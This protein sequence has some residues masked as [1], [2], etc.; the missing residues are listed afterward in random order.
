MMDEL[1]ATSTLFGSNAPFIEQQYEIY[2][3]DPNAVGADWRA[4]F[5]QLRDGASDVAHAPVIDSFIQLAKSRRLAAPMV[6]AQA[7]H[8]Q[9]LV[10]RL[11]SK[12]RT[13]GVFQADLDPLK[14]QEKPYLADLDLASYGFSEADREAEF[15]IGSYRGAPGGGDR[16]RLRDLIAALQETYCRTFATEYMYMSDTPQKRFIQER[17]EPLRSRP[18]YSPE[19]R[20]HILERLTAAETLERYLGTKYVGQKRFSGEGGDSMIPMLDHLIQTSGAAGVQ[21]MVIGM[22][23]RGRLNVLVN[24]LGK[25]PANLFAEFEGKSASDLSAG[26]VK[27]HQGFSSDVATPGGPMHVTLAFNPSHLEIVNPVV[28]GSVRARQ[29]RRK[30]GTFDQVMPVLIHG[31]AAIAGQGVV[32]ET[33]NLSQTRGFRTGGTIHIVVNNQ[34]GFTT[35]DPRDTRG[36]LYCTDV[37][38]MVEAPIFHVNGD[39]PEA[40]LLAIEIAIEFRQ[41]FDRDV[42]IDLVCFRRQGHNEADE[43]M[44][45]QP[46]MYKAIR[47][48][49]GTRALYA[50]RLVAEGVITAD[51]AEAMIATYRTAMDKG[52]HTNTTVLANYKPPFAVDWTPFLGKHWTDVAQTAVPLKTLKLLARKVTDVPANFKLHPRV[53]KVIADRRAMG[54]GEL[55]LDWGMGET[56]AYASLLDQGYGVRLSGQDSARGTFSHRHAVLHDQNRERWDEGIWIPLQHVKEGQPDFEIID[57]VL[58]EEAVLGFEYGYAT[59]EPTVLVIWE[60]QFGDFANGAQV[61]IDQFIAAGEVKWGRVCGL[62]LLLPHGYEGQGPEHSSARPERYLQLS[63]E[64]NMQVCVPTTPAQ[65]FHLL[66]RQ[67]VRDFRKPLIVMSPKSL[68]RHKAAVSALTDLSEG[69]FNTVIG[70]TEQLVAKNVRRVVVC[71]GKVYYDLTDFR[72]ASKIADM[73]VVRLEQLYPFPHLDFKEQIAKY[74]NAKEVVWCQEE[75]QNQGAWY[76]LRAYLRSDIEEKQLLAYAGRPISASPA[77]GYAS[78]HLAQQ[79]QLV[80]DA[81]APELASGEMIT[82][83]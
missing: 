52:L 57:S 45:T 53:E 20:R 81:F 61:V 73:A 79:Q 44:I 67:M 21:E 13:L 35:S 51:A 33:L 78:K 3:A 58:S 63:A 50:R 60:A 4:Y 40:C 24:T 34:I 12:Y 62:T 59:S 6:D 30:D 82:A 80:A 27:Y 70:D 1:R 49:P 32:Q 74:P 48:H 18:V 23:H 38:K 77:V 17:I 41:K 9:V 2:L 15:N 7:M 66:R 28:E 68:L 42:F 56:L 11:I 29:H 71:S 36:T 55:P 76:R 8:K 83:H 43:P 69:R 31:D 5:D 54:E 16:M 10:L 39:D 14:R 75:P 47:E 25:M 19:F 37:A 72:R 64:H 26:D 65:I 22:A 46:L